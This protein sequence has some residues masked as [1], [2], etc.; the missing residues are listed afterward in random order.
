MAHPQGTQGVVGRE[1]DYKVIK[2]S[3]E[4]TS[5]KAKV[6]LRSRA[7]QTQAQGVALGKDLP[8]RWNSVDRPFRKLSLGTCKQLWIT[9]VW[10]PATGAGDEAKEKSR[11]RL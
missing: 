4:L 6:L 10:V 5:C 3:E 11:D 7:V 8:G 9:T 1:T 2:D